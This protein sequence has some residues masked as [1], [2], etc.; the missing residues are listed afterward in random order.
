MYANT[1]IEVESSHLS[2]EAFSIQGH[3]CLNIQKLAKFVNMLPG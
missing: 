3:A 2:A 1:S